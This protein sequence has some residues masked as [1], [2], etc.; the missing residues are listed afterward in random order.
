MKDSTCKIEDLLFEF[1]MLYGFVS[2]P[3]KKILGAFVPRYYWISAFAGMTENLSDSQLIPNP[4]LYAKRYS[5]T[6]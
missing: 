4:M 2:S 1:F 3:Y 6:V 5:P